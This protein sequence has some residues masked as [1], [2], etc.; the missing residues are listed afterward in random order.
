MLPRAYCPRS[1]VCT[2]SRNTRSSCREPVMEPI[3]CVH[4]RIQEA[5][6]SPAVQGD[7]EAGRVSHP[8]ADLMDSSR[9]QLI[10]NRAL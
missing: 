4:Q 3:E 10:V 5:R 7:S 2:S 9:S 1:I 8:T 6:S